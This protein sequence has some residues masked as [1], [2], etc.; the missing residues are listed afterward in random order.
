MRSLEVTVDDRRVAL[1]VVHYRM[2]SLDEISAGT[3]VISV[4]AEASVEQSRGRHRVRMSNGYRSDVGVYLANAI[5][6]DSPAITIATQARDPRQQAL[7]IDYV[8][9]A[10]LAATATAWTLLALVLLGCG[11]WWRNG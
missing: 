2:P 1:R 10:P 5:R 7:T 3:G 6:P 9:D 8:V 4:V 11:A